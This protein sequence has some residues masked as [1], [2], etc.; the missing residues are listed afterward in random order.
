METALVQASK[1][2]DG[3]S[4]WKA[5][6]NGAKNFD[7]ALEVATASNIRAFLK[8]EKQGVQPPDSLALYAITQIDWHDLNCDYTYKLVRE[9]P[10]Y[11]PYFLTHDEW[12]IAGIMIELMEKRSDEVEKYRD[13][14]C[15][16]DRP[17]DILDDYL[18][19]FRGDEEMHAEVHSLWPEWSIREGWW[20][21]E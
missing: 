2:G 10:Q 7:E 16:E 6:R 20:R 11:L 14:F 8:L 19:G 3:P 17:S 18:D 21:E 4:A 1:K 13:L 15:M 5:V 9:N 12:L